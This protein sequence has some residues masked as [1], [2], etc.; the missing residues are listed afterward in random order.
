MKSFFFP[1]SFSGKTSIYVVFISGKFERSSFHFQFWG[2]FVL[3]E[4]VLMLLC[5]ILNWFVMKLMPVSRILVPFTFSE[6]SVSW[7]F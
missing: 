3:I 7:W 2:V 5:S 1:F 4:S 6:K